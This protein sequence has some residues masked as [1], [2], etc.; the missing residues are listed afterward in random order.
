MRFK[1]VELKK[2]CRLESVNHAFDL[3]ILNRLDFITHPCIVLS[4]II[5]TVCL[6]ICSKIRS[7]AGERLRVFVG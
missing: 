7:S 1:L 6:I 4:G 3:H 2:N 5:C